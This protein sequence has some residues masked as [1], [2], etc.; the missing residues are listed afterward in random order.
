MNKKKLNTKMRNICSLMAK[1]E[2]NQGKFK[3]IGVVFQSNN[4]KGRIRQSDKYGGLDPC[5]SSNVATS[6]A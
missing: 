1:L 4:N 5:H 6:I 3:T 2:I